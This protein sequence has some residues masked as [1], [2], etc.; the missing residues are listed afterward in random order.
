MHYYILLIYKKT[1]RDRIHHKT[2]DES[3]DKRQGKKP[4]SKAKGLT[5]Q[6]RIIFFIKIWN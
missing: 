6:S 4:N 2:Q 1:L 5:G 3:D